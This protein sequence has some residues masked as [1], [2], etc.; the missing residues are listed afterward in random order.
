MRV[1]LFERSWA[2]DVRCVRR[3]RE[4]VERC[5]GG[6]EGGGEDVSSAST[7]TPL[8]RE[9]IAQTI[10]VVCAQGHD[11]V[12]YYARRDQPMPPCPRCGKRPGE[13]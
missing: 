4:R 10:V 9:R 11:A 7:L 8:E 3:L 13:L 6:G 2:A 1:H 12:T 5:G